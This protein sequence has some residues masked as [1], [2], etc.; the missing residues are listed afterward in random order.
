MP[1]YPGEEPGKQQHPLFNPFHGDV[2]SV[3]SVMGRYVRVLESVIPNLG[4]FLDSLIS[5]DPAVRPSM[6]QALLEF[7]KI[8]SS[9]TQAQLSNEV[10][11]RFWHN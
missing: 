4:P 7:R 2:N 11:G 1:L 6:S 10:T 8:R 5:E 3:G 9:L